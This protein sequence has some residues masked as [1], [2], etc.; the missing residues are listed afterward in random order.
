MA[1]LC[2][3]VVEDDPDLREI[4]ARV[5]IPSIVGCTNVVACE[6]IV[7]LRRARLPEEPLIVLVTD[8]QL[9]NSTCADVIEYVLATFG[10]GRLCGHA[11]LTSANS[12]D[13]W[14]HVFS[15]ARAGGIELSYR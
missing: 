11:L 5:L 2:G 13:H 10:P 9:L 3:V 4:L 15:R 12:R 6:D 14:T 8:G 1:T 7:D